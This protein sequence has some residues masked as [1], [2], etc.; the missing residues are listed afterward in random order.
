MSQ[1]IQRNRGDIL[2]DRAPPSCVSD[3]KTRVW[4]ISN[5]V[6]E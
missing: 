2:R 6:F 1:E 5:L 4:G 3:F